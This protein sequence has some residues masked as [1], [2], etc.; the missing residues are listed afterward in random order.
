MKILTFRL[1]LLEP[2]MA[3]TPGGDPN[4][5]TTSDFI[6]GSMIRGA[7]IARYASVSGNDASGKGPA[8]LNAGDPEFARLFLDGTTRY[9]NGYPIEGLGRTIPTPL[10]WQRPT[11]EEEIACDFAVRQ[12]TN[13]NEKQWQPINTPFCQLRTEEDA[14]EEVL[15][16]TVVRP[17][18]TITVHTSRDRRY[19]RARSASG[20]VYQ[21]ESLEGGQSFQAVII[22]EHDS[23]AERLRELLGE[24]LRLGGSRSGGYGGVKVVEPKILDGTNWH[25]YGI[26]RSEGT[27]RTISITLLSD[28]ILRDGR[29]QYT[30]GAEVV[31]ETISPILGR[32]RL[33]VFPERTFIRG[34]LIGGFNRKWG[35]PLTQTPALRMGSVIVFK[36]E[37]DDEP[38]AEQFA[39]LESR[40]IGERRAEGFGRLG[41]NLHG[42][43]KI[44]IDKGGIGDKDPVTIGDPE[45]VKIARRMVTRLL[46]RG[47]DDEMAR[48]AN[49]L[50]IHIKTP[51]RSQLSRLR[52]AIREALGKDPAK[53]RLLLT[54]YFDSL[55]DRL[56]TR[57]QFTRD[58]VDNGSTIV[59]LRRRVNDTSGGEFLPGISLPKLG[60]NITASMTPE[61][62]YE[63]NLRLIDAVLMR[64]AKNR[65]SN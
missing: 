53:G 13:E 15:E 61:L 40:G 45:S 60:S 25:E 64:A 22:C 10:S 7:L 51:S 14:E 34:T 43:E 24:R 49:Q 4:S 12:I 37:G 32:V 38:T 18:H 6:P 20:A 36:I 16:A 46:R 42:A 26:S 17:S 8:N 2:L 30:I 28:V 52:L 41:I 65:G 59:W 55:E 62:I 23:D 54:T 35:L 21:Y 58:R 3:T 56:I 48:R 33:R 44:Q 11:D 50:G 19:G 39:R 5:E 1:E 31:A 27:P 29:G 57:G 9:L 47:L 63:Y